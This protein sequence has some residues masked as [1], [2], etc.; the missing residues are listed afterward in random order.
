MSTSIDVLPNQ[1]ALFEI[2]PEIT[3]LNCAYMSPQLRAATETGVR[4]VR[5]KAW[6]WTLSDATWFDAAEALRAA[7]ARLMEADA[8]GV[9]LIPA[10][11]YG[12]AVAKLAGLPPHG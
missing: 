5:Q 7:A 8:D 1:R 6:P 3:Y 11:S 10:V 2:P 9:A 4:A 12:I